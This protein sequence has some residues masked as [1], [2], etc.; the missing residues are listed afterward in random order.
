MLKTKCLLTAAALMLP[1]THAALASSDEAWK[2]LAK[3]VR[4]KC[5]EAALE[6]LKPVRVVVDPTGTDKYG[7]A[8]AFGKLKNSED[9]AS[10]ICL[11]DKTTK[12]VTLG[13]ELKEDVVRIRMPKKEGADS[14]KGKAKAAA[15]PAATSPAP[16]PTGTTAAP[17][18]E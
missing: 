2:A 9:R 4:A 6:H 3:D 8:I 15:A 7:L 17:A 11:Y 12:T 5:R 16:K 18:A 14:A 1:F 10:F 13:S